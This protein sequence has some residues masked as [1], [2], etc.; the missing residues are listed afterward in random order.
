MGQD[1]H[2]VPEDRR[3]GR[4]QRRWCDDLT[5]FHSDWWDAVKDHKTMG[6]PL[7]SSGIVWIREKKIECLSE[8]QDVWVRHPS[9]AGAAEV[10]FLSTRIE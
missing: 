8:T 10:F 9:H 4:P 5:L 7:T 2:T 6:R 3:R 1:R